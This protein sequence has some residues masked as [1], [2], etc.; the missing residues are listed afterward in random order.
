VSLSEANNM[1]LNFLKSNLHEVLN[2]IKPVIYR[3]QQAAMYLEF[4]KMSSGLEKIRLQN[5]PAIPM[6]NIKCIFLSL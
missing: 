1:G 2:E 5:Y 6:K 4:G 3:N